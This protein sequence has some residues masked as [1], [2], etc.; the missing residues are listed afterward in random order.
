M[1]RPEND[2]KDCRR[3]IAHPDRC[4]QVVKHRE[5]RKRDRHKKKRLFEQPLSVALSLICGCDADGAEGHDR[6]PLSVIAV[7]LRPYIDDLPDQ[8]T[9]RL[10]HKVQLRHESRVAAIA[11]QHIVLCAAGMANIPK[12]LAG[13][14][15]NVAIVVFVLQTNGNTNS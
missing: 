10:H 13:Q 12:R 3:K 2:H 11:V 7:D 6:H 8:L 1:R 14:V 15:F 9:V 4:E 5:H